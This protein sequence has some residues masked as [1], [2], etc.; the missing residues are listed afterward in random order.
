MEIVLM[1]THVLREVLDTTGEHRDL[2]F[3]R[4]GVALVR[5]V[6][7][8]YRVFVLDYRPLLFLLF[9]L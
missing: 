6:L 2:D 1:N 4:P 9:A 5:S 3:R 7:L 8:D